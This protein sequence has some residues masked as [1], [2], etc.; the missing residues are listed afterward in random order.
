M[1][2][3]FG[4]VFIQYIGISLLILRCSSSEKSEE[5]IIEVILNFFPETSSSKCSSI[6]ILNVA[7]I[8]RQGL[9]NSH[10]AV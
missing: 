8:R 9:K 6:F 1:L 7:F 3:L 5:D 2:L 4:S 10:Y